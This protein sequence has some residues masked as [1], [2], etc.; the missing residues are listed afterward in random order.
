MADTQNLV[1][2]GVAF[3]N[4]VGVVKN[5]YRISI[6]Y[7]YGGVVKNFVKKFRKVPSPSTLACDQTHDACP[8]L[9]AVNGALL[10]S[11][12]LKHSALNWA[13][14]AVMSPLSSH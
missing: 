7:N 9:D 11:F 1:Y 12:H 4:N 3:F 5:L 10:S 14:P 13:D 2:I 8:V 6:Y